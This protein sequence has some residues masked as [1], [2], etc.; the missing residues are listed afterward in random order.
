MDYFPVYLLLSPNQVLSPD[1]L[2]FK[3][4]EH[5]SIRVKR[6]LARALVDIPLHCHISRIDHTSVPL[7]IPDDF[8]NRSVAHVSN[9]CQV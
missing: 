5:E 2:G 9:L 6:K 8:R 7:E 3:V 4:Q 1:W